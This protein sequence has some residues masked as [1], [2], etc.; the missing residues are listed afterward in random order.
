MVITSRF[1]QITSSIQV[2][3]RVIPFPEVSVPHIRG[4]LYFP[5]HGFE[6][7]SIVES[8]VVPPLDDGVMLMLKRF[9][10]DSLCFSQ[11]HRGAENRG[12]VGNER[13]Y[14]I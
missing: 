13:V 5:S 11:V 6:W 2:V 4:R 12:R 9:W 3:F 1:V 10:D 14:D 8:L 7:E